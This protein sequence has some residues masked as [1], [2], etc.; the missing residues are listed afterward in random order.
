MQKIAICQVAV[1]S[2]LLDCFL[3]SFL[4]AELRSMAASIPEVIV[5][6]WL[7]GLSTPALH[8]ITMLWDNLDEQCVASTD[9]AA[10]EPPVC[11]SISHSRAAVG[12]SQKWPARGGH[13]PAQPCCHALPLSS[14]VTN[15]VEASLTVDTPERRG[16]RQMGD[17]PGE[18]HPLGRTVGREQE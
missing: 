8:S 6:G 9:L 12:V 18:R 1:K 14:I 7:A 15:R 5:F 16:Q 11:V 13:V 2:R 4:C 17:R 3:A 10:A